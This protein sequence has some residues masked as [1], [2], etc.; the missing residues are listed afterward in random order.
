MRAWWDRLERSGM[1]VRTL[2]IFEEGIDPD[3]A[4]TRDER[5]EFGLECLLDGIAARL[6][7]AVA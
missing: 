5:F 6:G 1:L 4:E 3:A 7:Q 2:R